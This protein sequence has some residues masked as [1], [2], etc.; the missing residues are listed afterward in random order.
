MTE[1]ALDLQIVRHSTAKENIAII[2]KQIE[3][4]GSPSWLDRAAHPK[5]NTLSIFGFSL[6]AGPDNTGGVPLIKQHM[7]YAPNT[8][9]HVIFCFQHQGS[10]GDLAR[11]TVVSDW[12]FNDIPDCNDT[13]YVWCH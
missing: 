3:A 1:S 2:R 11:L 9:I 10:L 13:K 8:T 4:T 6:D 5:E 12:K 7:K